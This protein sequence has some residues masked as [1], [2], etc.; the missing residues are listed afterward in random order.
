MKNIVITNSENKKQILKNRTTLIDEK[1]IT[2]DEFISNMTFSYDEKTIYY[3]MKKYNLKYDICLVYLKN[4]IYVDDNTSFLGKLK[5]ELLSEGLISYND[6][7]KKQLNNYNIIVDTPI[8]KFEKKLLSNFS[9][10]LKTKELVKKEYDVYEFS[11]IEEEVDFIA[12]K[13][14]DLLHNECDIQ[15]IKLVNVSDEYYPFV[16]RIFSF[17]NLPIDNEYTLYSHGEFLNFINKLKETKDLQLSLEVIETLKIKK[18]IISLINRYIFVKDID[19]LF[20]QILISES[21]KI[22]LKSTSY[23]NKITICNHITEDDIAFVVGFNDSYPKYRKDEDFFSDTY[24]EQLGVDT[25]LDENRKI[26]EQLLLEYSLSQQTIFTYSTRTKSGEYQISPISGFIE[27]NLI[28]IND[29]FFKYSDIA[30]HLKLSRYLDYKNKYNVNNKNLNFLKFN[31]KELPYKK[32]DNKFTGINKETMYKF[33]NNKLLLSYSSMDNYYKCSFK[34]YLNNILKVTQYEET[35]ATEIGNIFHR[36]LE[37][38]NEPDFNFDSS[39]NKEI[40]QLVLDHKSQVFYDKLRNDLKFVI[41]TINKQNRFS[42]FDNELHEKKVYINKDNTISITF[43]GVIDKIKWKEQ[44]GK[45]ILAIIDYKTGNPITNISKSYYGLD[46][47][48]P[49]YLYLAHHID[50]FSNVEVVGIYLQKILN[51]ESYYDSKKDYI[52]Q[53][54]DNLK[55]DGYSLDDTNLVEQFDTTYQDSELIKSMKFGKN[56]FYGY[57][58]I[59]TKEQMNSLYR[60]VENK[61]DSSIKHILEADFEIN[62]KKMDKDNTCKYCP[63][64]DICHRKEEDYIQIEIPKTLDFLSEVDYDNMD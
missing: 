62:P 5:N 41:D 48:L 42:T 39:Y 59:L 47:Q 54:E 50:G 29:S 56:G 49:I 36:I 8:G 17:Y 18:T 37:K 9:Y 33:L 7:F 2:L 46:M 14:C 58:K 24:K 26:D 44:D 23:L 19:D 55:L 38:Y 60:L 1:I 53:K 31:Y 45:T 22:K 63:Y 35:F 52:K 13:I 11:N 10:K 20:M 25:S 40:S 28:K 6:N 30:N 43:M 34:Y 3:L 21:K 64:Q 4:M 32:Y 51:T 57:T 12:N 15:K 16:K 27:Y 61:V